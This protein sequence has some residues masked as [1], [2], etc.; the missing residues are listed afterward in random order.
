MDASTSHGGYQSCAKEKLCHEEG[1][2]NYLQGLASHWRRALISMPILQR[3]IEPALAVRDARFIHFGSLHYLLI[4]GWW[5]RRIHVCRYSRSTTMENL[6]EALISIIEHCP[7]LEIF[8]ID[9]PMGE[10]FGQSLTPLPP[11]EDAVPLGSASDLQI[12]LPHLQQLSLCGF[13]AQFLEEA[14]GWSMP[15]LRCVSF[16]CGNHSY[17]L[18]DAVEFLAAHGSELTFLDLNCIPVLD[19]PRILDLCPKLVTFSFNADW[20]L[21]PPGDEPHPTTSL[22]VARAMKEPMS[23]LVNEPHLNI[24]TIG[25]HG[26]MYAFGVGYA[27]HFAM[28]YR[29]QAQT[30]RES[31]DLNMAALNKTNFPKLQTVRTLSRA[32]LNDLNEENGPA[33]DGGVQRYDKWWDK[34]TRSGIRLEDCT[35]ALLGTLPMDDGDE[36]DDGDDVDGEEGED[37]DEEASD[38]DDYEEDDGEEEDEWELDVPPIPQVGGSQLT[39]LRQLLAECRAMAETREPSIFTPMLAETGGMV[40]PVVTFSPP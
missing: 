5:T 26:L 28:T 27:G 40:M 20:Y 22:T 32:M 37:E 9:V 29:V 21:L 15:S 6:D 23:V 8:I 3:T 14:T 19:V 33:E 17:D 7:N 2:Y 13:F 36:E 31:N 35:G 4:L 11:G 16:D 34:L 39:E 18:P 1:N 12:S 30:V 24:T 38:D 25:L 10:T